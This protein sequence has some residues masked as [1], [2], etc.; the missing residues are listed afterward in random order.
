GCKHWLAKLEKVNKDL[1]DQVHIFNSFFYKKLNQLR[2]ECICDMFIEY[3]LFINLYRI[4]SAY[5]GIHNWMG[6]IDIFK[7]KFIVIPINKKYV[8]YVHDGRFYALTL[9]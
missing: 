8:S 7:K 6:K 3:L 9:P 5:E 1:V 2:N 4:Q